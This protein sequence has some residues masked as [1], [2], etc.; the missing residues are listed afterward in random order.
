MNKINQSIFIFLTVLFLGCNSV[1][2]NN[3][4]GRYY[5]KKDN[6]TN[7]LELYKNG[8]FLHY[9]S[10]NDSII[11]HRGLWK[12]SSDGFCKIEF[13]GWKNFEGK[14]FDFEKFGNQILFIQN[15]GNVL[16]HSPDGSNSNSFIK[17]SNTN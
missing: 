9:Y 2:K 16:N 4:E 15:N 13:D 11:T 1:C 14:G 3:L 8:E 6:A 5:V 10:E 12:K 17:S 7:Y